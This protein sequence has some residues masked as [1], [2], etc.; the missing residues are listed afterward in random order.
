M[1]LNVCIIERRFETSSPACVPWWCQF[2]MAGAKLDIICPAC[3]TSFHIHLEFT[4][5]IFTSLH[6]RFRTE[7]PT[8]R[9]SAQFT[10]RICDSSDFKQFLPTRF[11]PGTCSYGEPSH[12]TPSVTEA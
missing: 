9:V 1:G 6:A 11:T 3:S 7:T 10:L 5:L 12:P 8:R 2:E 4:P